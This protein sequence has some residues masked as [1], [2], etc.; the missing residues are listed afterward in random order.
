[1]KL[2]R[3]LALLLFAHAAS[4]ATLTDHW[5]N[6]EHPGWGLMLEQ[7][8]EG[9]YALLYDYGDD[10]S[11]RWYVAPALERYALT[12]SG[13]P[14]FRGALYRVAGSP[15][16]AA[17][18]PARRSQTAVGTV[19]VSPMAFDRLVLTTTI[20]GRERVQTASRLT[21]ATPQY[22]YRYLAGFALRR[23]V[24][25]QPAPSVLNFFAPLDVERDGNRLRM[26]HVHETR[27]CLYDGLYRQDGRLGTAIGTYRCSETDIGTFTASE[28]ETTS[29]GITGR[30]ELRGANYREY[31]RFGGTVQYS[32]ATGPVD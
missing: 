26:Q 21:W 15:Y 24:E 10:G 29:N 25:G 8:D 4:A 9:A 6:P 23:L 31:G 14:V 3:C 7:A 12:G 19:D 28:L 16:G 11:A 5:W 1:M 13:L 18:D 2:L 17:F 32:H 22:G 20:G 30:I 27:S